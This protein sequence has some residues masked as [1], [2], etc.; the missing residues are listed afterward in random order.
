[1]RELKIKFAR[2]LGISN[3][4]LSDSQATR[5]AARIRQLSYSDRT[6]TRI[7]S[8]VTDITGISSFSISESSIDPSDINDIID[9][10]DDALGTS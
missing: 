7:K 5:I 4:E 10:I 9:Q 1:M 2:A 8:I 6:A 3:H